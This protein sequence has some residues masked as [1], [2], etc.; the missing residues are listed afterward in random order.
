MKT[1]KSLK[2]LTAALLILTLLVPGFS[3][4]L[5]QEVD[6]NPCISVTTYEEITDQDALLDLALEQ[7]AA[8]PMT[9]DADSTDSGSEEIVATQLLAERE[10]QDGTTIKDYAATSFLL[11]DESGKK[12][13]ASDVIVDQNKTVTGSYR[14]SYT[15]VTAYYQLNWGSGEPVF[16]ELTARILYV[17]VTPHNDV[18]DPS[19]K[20]SSMYYGI[21]CAH[22]NGVDLL[23]VTSTVN[24]P[25]S[26]VMYTKYNTSSE[27]YHIYYDMPVT[28]QAGADLYMNDGNMY[29]AMVN[30]KDLTKIA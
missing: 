3:S 14:N 19:R 30:L 7:L 24:N 11:I 16:A 18:T 20:I 17:K 9:M 28:C 1:K 10:Y 27:W 8:K 29:T 13:T 26:G 22:R 25:A 2:K 4:V 15:T 23:A 6:K 5:A 12:M 21:E